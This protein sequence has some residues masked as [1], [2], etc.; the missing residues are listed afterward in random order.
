[1]KVK[2]FLD[3]LELAYKEPNYYKSGGWGMWDGSKWGW[4]C[5][6]IIKGILWGWNNDKSKP[7]GGGAVYGSNGVPDIGEDGL[8]NSC[9]NVSSD[10]TNLTPGEL[11]YMQ[12]HCGIYIGNRTVIEAT[13][14]W[15]TDKVIKTQVDNLGNRSYNGQIERKWL[16][17][18]LLPWID[19]DDQIEPVG[20][21]FVANGEYVLDIA[22]C[23]HT[24]PSLGNN[25][26]QAERVDDFTKTILESTTG[27]AMIKKGIELQ[28]L[29]I[30]KENGRTWGSYGN[31]WIELENEYGEKQAT[32]T[33]QDKV[34]EYFLEGQTYKLLYDKCIRTSPELANNI[35]QATRVDAFTKTLLASQTGNAMLRAGT[36]I[37]CL[38]ITKENGRIWGSYGNC[39]ICLC[40]DD[41]TKQAT[42]I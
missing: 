14:G 11:L 42:R 9:K 31:C 35:L 28:P 23:I 30:K 12:G 8:I 16:K 36:E 33:N 24:I 40:N 22:K 17:H 6:C 19:Y 39:W 3:K 20:E 18:G 41:G 7:R 32:K 21:Y 15:G 26:M 34:E 10:F 13:K 4:D 2:E 38:K 25:V 5:I 37:T 29:E 27:N 1:M